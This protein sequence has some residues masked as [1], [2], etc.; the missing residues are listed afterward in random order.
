MG[1]AL[2]AG[3][4]KK[5]A[6]EWPGDKMPAVWALIHPRNA[7]SQRIFKMH[8]FSWVGAQAG[9][10]PWLRPYGLPLF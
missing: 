3:T 9:D 10:H 8:G 1:D 2:L 7:D 6:V 4:L 5:I